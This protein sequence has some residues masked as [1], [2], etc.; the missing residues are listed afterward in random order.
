V[1]F[2][3]GVWHVLSD[4]YTVIKVVDGILRFTDGGGLKVRLDYYY[5][6]SGTHEKQY[7]ALV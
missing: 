5:L 7:W 4:V 3:E 2:L 6:H 1:G